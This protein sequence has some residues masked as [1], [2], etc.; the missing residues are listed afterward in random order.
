MMKRFRKTSIHKVGNNK[1]FEKARSGVLEY[2]AFPP[3]G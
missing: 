1:V 2:K 3:G